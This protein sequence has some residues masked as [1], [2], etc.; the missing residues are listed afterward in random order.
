MPEEIYT[1]LREYLDGMPGGF[2]STESG[3]ELRILE[4]MFTPEDARLTMQLRLFPEPPAVIAKRWGVSEERAAEKLAEMAETGIIIRIHSGKQDFYQAT[5]YQ[6]GFLEFFVT[7]ID[8]ELA[9]MV[10]E[11]EP[12]LGDSVLQQHR[13][14]P[15]GAAVDPASSIASYDK[16]KEIIKK[17]K[18]AAVAECICK[19]EKGLL[20]SECAKPHE[21]CLSFGIGADHMIR[22][23]KGREIGIDEALRIVDRAEENAMILMPT[24]A[25][26][27]VHMCCCCSCCC[28]LLRML[29]AHDK[30]ADFVIGLQT[31]HLR[32]AAYRT[33]GKKVI[34]PPNL[35]VTANNHIGIEYCSCAN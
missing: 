10:M 12:H 17:Q 23:G 8:R 21:T 11:F 16:A 20:G 14:I 28:A 25:R 22:T 26:D 18:L 4:K 7:T 33:I 34:V 15:V 5:Q 27:I 35:D 29:K 30:P 19:K 24:N 32:P 1:Q 31:Q 3:V 13:V 6:V 9:E 2:P